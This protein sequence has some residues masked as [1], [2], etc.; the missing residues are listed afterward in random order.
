MPFLLALTRLVRH[1]T[2]TVRYPGGTERRYGD[3]GAPCAGMHI[4][5][6][7]ALRRLTFNAGLALGEAYMDGAVEPVGCSIYD[8]LEFLTRTMAQ[9]GSHLVEHLREHPREHLRRATRLLA[10]VNPAPRARRNVAHHDDLDGR[11][12]CLFL[13][14]DRQYSCA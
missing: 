12:Y 10:Q 8:L 9:G 3:G 2:L 7:R 6:G 14:R 5:T 1:G 4:R 13:D 11:L